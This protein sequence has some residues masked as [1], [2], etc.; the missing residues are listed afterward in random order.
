MGERASEKANKYGWG[1][2]HLPWPSRFVG[3]KKDNPS[4]LYTTFVRRG[5]FSE[6]LVNEDDSTAHN[7]RNS[8]SPPC[9]EFK[10]NSHQKPKDFRSFAELVCL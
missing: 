8:V 10:I 9:E 2:L 7:M 3:G 5:L 1:N 4:A 6:L